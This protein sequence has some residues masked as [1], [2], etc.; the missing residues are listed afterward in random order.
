MILHHFNLR[1]QPFG[2]TPDSRYLYATATQ[3]E[4]LASVLFGIES[5]LGF[6]ALTAK[7]G[8]GKTTLLF[9]A[10][11]R[12]GDKAKTVF[13]FQTI[14]TPEDLLRAL[15]VDLGVK[16]IKG[17][18]AETQSQLNEFL[19]NLNATGKRLV[20]AIDEAQNLSESVLEAVRM[21]S[22]FETPRQKLI[23]FI[24]SG[25]PQLETRLALPQMLQL[26]QRIS[27]FA[28]L[29]AL[30]EKEVAGYIQH[31]LRLA[32]DASLNPIFSAS[33]V[34]LIARH[35]EGIP[36]NINNIC[37]NAMSLACALKR[38][39]IGS[40][41]IEE[42]LKDL[43]VKD[44]D[45]PPAS[46]S[47]H[48]NGTGHAMNSNSHRGSVRL[49]ARIR[50]AALAV[51]TIVLVLGWPS[52]KDFR[53]VSASDA[54]HTRS[55]AMVPTVV[56]SASTLAPTEIALSLPASSFIS[57]SGASER[58]SIPE[59]SGTVKLPQERLVQVQRG[60]ILSGICAKAFG[61]CSPIELR[62]IVNTNPRI[63][64][65]NLI[66]YGQW[67]TIAADRSR[68]TDKQ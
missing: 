50:S 1:E 19:V 3:Q 16:E 13:L 28:H 46:Q 39:M 58:H 51:C 45:S 48:A 2:V 65:P 8:M 15:L 17:S 32:G 24:L 59:A 26:R 18:L 4:A 20:V 64:D 68:P 44:F 37:F 11:R 63:S 53:V 34:A 14:S 62:E 38:R 41:L 6:V 43:Q 67:I 12:I 36:R 30:S 55:G 49:R 35:S 25:Q 29:E 47:Q 9:E 33:A 27:I 22:N 60:E 31:R 40:T 42:V 57:P 23:Q 52:F 5:G 66:K 10:I 56:T 7:P 21:L 61:E 54:V